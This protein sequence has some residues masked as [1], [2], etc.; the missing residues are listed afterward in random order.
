MTDVPFRFEIGAEAL[1]DTSLE[2]YFDDQNNSLHLIFSP[3]LQECLELANTIDEHQ[4]QEASKIAATQ[5]PS[6]ILVTSH[7]CDIFYS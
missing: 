4:L 2:N 1:S 3:H 5:P 7:I 6:T